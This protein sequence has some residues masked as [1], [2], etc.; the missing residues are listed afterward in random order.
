[1]NSS[2]T[3][4]LVHGHLVSRHVLCWFLSVPP[5][6]LC[7]YTS[8][9]S[10]KQSTI[11]KHDPCNSFCSVSSNCFWT[12]ECLSY[13]KNQVSW[14]RNQTTYSRFLKIVLL[15]GDLGNSAHPHNHHNQLD[16]IIFPV[17]PTLTIR[18]KINVTNMWHFYFERLVTKQNGQGTEQ[19]A[20]AKHF[21]WDQWQFPIALSANPAPS[22]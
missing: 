20:S 19:L 2:Y 9:L 10:W 7:F 17:Q 16:I 6:A 13:V 1:M 4:V 8:V 21:Y 14:T 12:Q 22:L 3:I 5:W 11:E 15:T 18:G